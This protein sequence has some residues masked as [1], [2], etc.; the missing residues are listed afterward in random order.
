MWGGWY[1]SEEIMKNLQKMKAICEGAIKKDSSS[2]PSAETVM[3]IDEKAYFNLPWS[4]PLRHSVNITRTEMGNTGIPF[5]MCMTEDAEKVLGRYRAAIFTAPLPSESGKSAAKL[6]QKLG[7]PYIEISQ[8]KPYY[9][10]DE[11]RDFLVS[12][13]VHCYNPEGNVIFCGEGFLGIH[14]VK[15]GMAEIRLPKKYTVRVLFGADLAECE[16]DVI[17]LNMK[18]H[19]TAV[20]ELI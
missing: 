2:Y 19:E 17:T 5:D 7:I 6:C 11:L 20:F 16:T 3:F 15:D 12:S 8:E 18:K 1:H 10:K 9:T 14:A 4:D 13:G